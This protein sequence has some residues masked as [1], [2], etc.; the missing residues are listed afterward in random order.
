MDK[1]VAPPSRIRLGQTGIEW[2]EGAPRPAAAKRH[3]LAETLA[4]GSLTAAVAILWA[5]ALIW[6]GH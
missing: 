2:N 3:A 4:W 1:P 5:V 6:S